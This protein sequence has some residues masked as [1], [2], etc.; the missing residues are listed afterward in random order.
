MMTLAVPAVRRYHASFMGRPANTTRYALVTGAANGL[1]RALAVRLA[2]DGWHIAV[3]DVDEPGSRETLRLIEAAGGQGRT[4]HLDVRHFD[5][6]RALVE[7]LQADWP[8]L[9]ML[10]NNA[11]VACSGQVG[12][13][14]LEDW[15]WLID[16]NLFGVINGCHA[17]LDW[18]KR[19]PG[20]ASLVNVASVAAVLAAPAM[21]TYN[22]AKAGVLA[23]SETMACELYGTNVR[24]TV[25]CPG[26]F[27]TRLLD[28]GRFQTR[29]ERDTAERYTS[30]APMNA[31]QIADAIIRAAYRGKLHV[32]LPARARW[33]WY[34]RR[35]APGM[36]I[37]LLGIGY[38]RDLAKAGNFKP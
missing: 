24:V 5:E 9:D 32:F 33:L 20:R 27:R 31:D 17:G 35:L 34:L 18:L 26:F 12:I 3:A 19:H 22:V 11:G 14:P 30:T 10:V 36:L 28:C 21:A 29:L 4:E 15:R 1:G 2:R 25:A 16:T 37:K 38:A 8:R 23:L 6:W 13:T 7:R